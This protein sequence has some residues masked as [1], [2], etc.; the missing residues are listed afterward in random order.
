MITKAIFYGLKCDRC[1]EVY[2]DGEGHTH[3][4]DEDSA[5]E[6]AIGFDEESEWIEEDGKHYCPECYTVDEETDEVKILPPIPAHVKKIQAFIEKVIRTPV[7]MNEVTEICRLSF[8]VPASKTL[9]SCDEN[10]I[11]NYLG[12]KLINL[13]YYGDFMNSECIIEI[14]K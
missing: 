14:K 7:H 4:P 11:R 10:Y 5:V 8:Y 13:A 9:Q 12:D 6:F 2:E 1:G 3:W